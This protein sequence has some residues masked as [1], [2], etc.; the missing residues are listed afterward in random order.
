MSK[1]NKRSLYLLYAATF[2]IFLNF[3]IAQTITPLY[4]L[5]VGGTEFFSGLQSTLFFLTAVVLRFY[6]GPLADRKGNRITLF[7]GGLA[8]MTAPL[9]FLLHQSVGYILFVRVY[10]AIGLGAYFS[11]ASAMVSALAPQKRL[12]TYIGFYRL[13]TMSTLMIGPSLALKIIAEYGYNWYHILGIVAGFLAMAF[14][15]FV[16]EPEELKKNRSR[17]STEA[18]FKMLDLLKE[19]ELS[20]IYRSTFIVAFCYGLLITF[21]AIYIV[22]QMPEINPG[23]FFTVFGLGSIVANLTAGPLSDRKGRTTVVFPC[24]LILAF[25]IGIFYFFPIKPWI[26]YGASILTGF[27]FAGSVS[28]LITWLVDHVP[29]TRRTTALALQDS[30]MDIGIGLGSFIFGVLIPMI[31]MPWSYG[32]SGGLLFLFGFW[33]TFGLLRKE[34]AAAS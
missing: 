15:H 33:K 7:I 3:N 19:K 4:I 23:I 22:Q 12:G 21:T 2:F 24:I 18:G 1:E 26:L 29:L 28:V 34:T 13:V 9:L 17:K 11:S 16:R 14:L 8:F 30:A 32:I 27:G 6:F 25:G 10:Q 20:P 31:G 5:D